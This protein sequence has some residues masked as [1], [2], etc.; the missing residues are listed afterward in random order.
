MSRMNDLLDFSP[1]IA[2]VESVAELLQAAIQVFKRQRGPLARE[3]DV[4]SA[5]RRFE[6]L[7]AVA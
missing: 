1:V 6:P 7:I 5:C 4:N 3:L 2:G